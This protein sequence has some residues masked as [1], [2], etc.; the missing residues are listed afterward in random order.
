[1]TYTRHLSEKVGQIDKATGLLVRAMPA[2]NFEYQAKL[3][4]KVMHARWP[5]IDCDELMFRIRQSLAVGSAWLWPEP[6]Q[7]DLFTVESV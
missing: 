3:H 5:F 2:F 6:K 1:M 7:L 4:F